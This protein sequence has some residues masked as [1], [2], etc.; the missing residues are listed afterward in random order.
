MKEKKERKQKKKFLNAT[1]KQ[2]DVNY[3]LKVAIHPVGR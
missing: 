2:A 1:L 3:Q